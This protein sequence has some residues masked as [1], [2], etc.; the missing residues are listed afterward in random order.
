MLGCV[1]HA[2]VLGHR[3]QQETG[4][5]LHLLALLTSCFGAVVL[6]SC[7]LLYFS[8]KSPRVEQN[9][10]CCGGI[11]PS[12]DDK[13]D[14]SSDTFVW[15]SKK[16]MEW[17]LPPFPADPLWYVT[18]LHA[19][20]ALTSVSSAASLILKSWDRHC[21]LLFLRINQ[22]GN[23]SWSPQK[24]NIWAINNSMV[25]GI[26]WKESINQMGKSSKCWGKDHAKEVRE[27]KEIHPFSWG[28]E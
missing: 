21:R 13:A 12:I 26:L 1:R 2:S 17:I 15:G 7:I 11:Y 14:C 19:C 20:M 22:F 24:I 5:A 3:L 6:Q 27:E 10:K 25:G 23:I 4:R 28:K 9:R 18:L 8:S 16:H